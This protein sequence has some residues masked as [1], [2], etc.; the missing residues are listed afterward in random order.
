MMPARPLAG[1]QSG[2][3]PQAVERRL[4][5][6][7]EPDDQDIVHPTKS[8]VL[9]FE[10][11]CKLD[12]YT[13]VGTLIFRQW[14]QAIDLSRIA[15]R[16]EPIPLS[17]PEFPYNSNAWRSGRRLIALISCCFLYGIAT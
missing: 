5:A 7:T 15:I 8:N 3:L 13:A 4:S 16:G 9:H 6:R 17:P 10:A 2:L 14:G 1:P 12:W 11:G